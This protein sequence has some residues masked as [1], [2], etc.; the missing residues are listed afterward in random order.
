M[1]ENIRV[2]QCKSKLTS[3]L[4]RISISPIDVNI[5]A[6]CKLNNRDRK[7]HF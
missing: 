4:L 6:Q 1:F 3:Q 2:F 5:D 7:S